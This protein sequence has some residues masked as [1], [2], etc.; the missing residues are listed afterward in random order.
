MQGCA[1][2]QV[3]EWECVNVRGWVGGAVV[4]KEGMKEVCCTK[5][6]KRRALPEIESGTSRTQIENHT[7]RPRG[8]NKRNRLRISHTPQDQQYNNKHDTTNTT[9]TT[10]SHRSVLPSHRLHTNT[11]SVSVSVS[12]LRHNQPSAVTPAPTPQLVH[13]RCPCCPRYAVVPWSLPSSS[14]S[15]LLSRDKR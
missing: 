5:K 1:E 10:P 3:C 6:A 2:R 8:Q 9:H 7:T 14:R 11:H 13:L 4:T 12:L 15:S